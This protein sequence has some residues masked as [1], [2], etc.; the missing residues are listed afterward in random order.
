MSPKVQ[1]DPR[2]IEPGLWEDKRRLMCNS[3]R[4]GA[5]FLDRDGVLNVDTGYVGDVTFLKVCLELAPLIRQA[6]LNNMPVIIVTN[7]SG[8][9]RGYYTWSDFDAVNQ[10]IIHEFSKLGAQIDAVFAC[11]YHA[12]AK[13]PYKFADHPWRKPSPGMLLRASEL[14]DID[15]PKSLLIGDK[16]SDIEAARR[17]GLKKAIRL[18]DSLSIKDP[19]EVDNSGFEVTSHTLRGTDWGGF[20]LPVNELCKPNK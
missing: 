20:P 19:L 13:P 3:E 2:Q 14:Y 5:L 7:Q 9:G 18:T 4:T 1:S 17:A 6:N 12:K 11:A 10:K 8:I 16:P 15:L